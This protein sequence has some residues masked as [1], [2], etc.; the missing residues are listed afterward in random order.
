MYVHL[1]WFTENCSSKDGGKLSEFRVL[2][3]TFICYI[4]KKLNT[5]DQ[6]FPEANYKRECAINRV[7]ALNRYN[8]V[9]TKKCFGVQTIKSD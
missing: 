6:N 1:L 8:T 7:C 9:V 4:D 2:H 3:T 5:S